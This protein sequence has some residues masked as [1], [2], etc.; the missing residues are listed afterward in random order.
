MGSNL[1]LYQSAWH[2]PQSY[3][4]MAQPHRYD[5][6]GFPNQAAKTSALSACPPKGTRA[7][8]TLVRQALEPAWEAKLAP[9]TYGFRPGRSCLDAIEAIFNAIRYRP[10]YALKIDI[11]KC[12][13]R[14]DHQ[15]LLA[16]TQSS[17][18]SVD[19]SKPGSVRELSKTS[20]S[21]PP[22]QGPRKGG[23]FPLC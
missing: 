9:H 10:Q 2:W 4:S 3:G 16:K 1:S 23:R 5:A 18:T 14:I 15:A 22:P 11:A 19:N 6:H 12:F 17:P 8:Q 13:D 7:R 21:C 20:A